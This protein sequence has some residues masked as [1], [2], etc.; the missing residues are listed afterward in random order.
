MIDDA[1]YPA[2]IPLRR[3][4]A[5][6]LAGRLEQLDSMTG[7]FLTF[8]MIPVEERIGEWRFAGASRSLGQALRRVDEYAREIGLA[9]EDAESAL[10][11]WLKASAIEVWTETDAAWSYKHLPLKEIGKHRLVL[12]AEGQAP[13][14]DLGL[15][16]LEIES[17]ERS[18]WAA[19]VP[20][21]QR[22]ET[23]P[24]TWPE[25]D[26]DDEA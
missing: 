14:D 23:W 25:R 6:E 7:A 11:E 24:D 15:C 13:Y 26:E 8:V 9:M 21:T 19:R 3:E 22:P 20:E 16:V 2:P 18:G 1:L 12:F 10:V 4:H 17:L 5:L